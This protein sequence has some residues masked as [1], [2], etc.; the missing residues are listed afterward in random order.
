M[1]PTPG[2]VPP[3]TS[4]KTPVTMSTTDLLKI[5]IT[6]QNNKVLTICQEIGTVYDPTFTEVEDA[7]IGILMNKA[8]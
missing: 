7:A 4:K 8:L 1:S 6:Y 3:S 2:F 5:R